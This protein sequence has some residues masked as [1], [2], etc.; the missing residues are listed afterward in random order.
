MSSVSLNATE[1]SR[2]QT[3]PRLLGSLT[4]TTRWP[5][6]IRQSVTSVM[7]RLRYFWANFSIEHGFTTFGFV[8]SLLIVAMFAV[9]LGWGWPLYRADPISDVIL[10]ASGFVLLLMCISL[11]YD[12]TRKHKLML[13]R[14]RYRNRLRRL[15]KNER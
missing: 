14:E 1:E 3:T 10:I 15:N 4:V 5:D 7:P 8:S 12:Q 11:F 13:L 2:Q 9:D 6:T